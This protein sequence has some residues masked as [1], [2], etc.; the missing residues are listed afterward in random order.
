[1]S[2]IEK[3]LESEQARQDVLGPYQQGPCIGLPGIAHWERTQAGAW[4]QV[5]LW[6]HHGETVRAYYRPDGDRYI[7]SDL[8]EG[9]KALRLRTGIGMV[10]ADAA[11]VGY[12][13]FGANFMYPEFG[14]RC[15][16]AGLD[17]AICRVLLAS[18]RVANLAA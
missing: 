7:V 10:Q 15:D 17:D 8:G 11:I 4:T 9:V 1:M 12:G 6:R 18:Y 16:M 14:L 13:L 2:E 5:H 3:Y